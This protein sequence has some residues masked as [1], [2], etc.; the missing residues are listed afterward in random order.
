MDGGV[1]FETKSKPFYGACILLYLAVV[2]PCS[3][4]C[5]TLWYVLYCMQ[6]KQ[7]LGFY[8]QRLLYTFK[9]LP[10]TTL[11]SRALYLYSVATSNGEQQT[12]F[13]YHDTGSGVNTVTVFE[14]KCGIT[15]YTYSSPKFSFSLSLKLYY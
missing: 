15:A 8:T 1:F 3:F 2:L 9:L 4:G 5:A 6:Q 13:V 11:H 7:P 12:G 14:N 10:S